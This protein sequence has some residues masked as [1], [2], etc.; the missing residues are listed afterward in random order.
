MLRVHPLLL[1]VLAPQY[2]AHKRVNL[3]GQ[4]GC[5]VERNWDDWVARQDGG[6]PRR[7]NRFMPVV[8]Y[9]YPAFMRLVMVEIGKGRLLV[10]YVRET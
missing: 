3:L 7:H 6:R 9:R 4:Q 10:Y 1:R 5:E 2:C 8:S